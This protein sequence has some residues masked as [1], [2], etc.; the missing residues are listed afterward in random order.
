MVAFI[1]FSFSCTR[2][3]EERVYTVPAK[4]QKKIKIVQVEKISG[5]TIDFS[6]E[7]AGRIFGDNIR[8]R[9]HRVLREELIFDENDIKSI[10]RE[11]KRKILEITTKKGKTYQAYY[12]ANSGRREKGKLYVVI[13]RDEYT[14]VSIPLSEVKDMTI[15]YGKFDLGLTALAVLG[16]VVGAALTFYLLIE[17]MESQMKKM[18][19]HL[20]D[21]NR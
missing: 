5:E 10:K 3:I 12:Q 19:F 20:F 9:A 1:V 21:A 15:K 13:H 4:N 8:G 2:M 16:Y 7:E 14:P 6:E 17:S 18:N 11:S